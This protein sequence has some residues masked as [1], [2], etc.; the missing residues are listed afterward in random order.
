MRSG[1]LCA[2]VLAVSVLLLALCL[3]LDVCVRGPLRRQVTEGPWR[4]EAAFRRPEADRWAFSEA[5]AAGDVACVERLLEAGADVNAAL[6]CGFA[7][8][9]LAAL[10]GQCEVAALLLEHG[11]NAA[12]TTHL[13]T[14]ALHMVGMGSYYAGDAEG[15]AELIG[16][17]VRHG[18][19]VDATTP[20]GSTPLHR[21]AAYGDVGAIGALIAAGADVNAQT[22]TG[23]T[24]L[25]VALRFGYAEATEALT[26]HGAQGGDVPQ[27]ARRRP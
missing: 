10:A 17:L 23:S 11:A 20:S 2:V 26:T 18:A 3:L 1:R 27:A 7:P 25:S 19:K 5:V 13:G 8:L 4:P 22:T 12:A 9:H 21:A 15:A 14:S 6:D 16:L 24:P